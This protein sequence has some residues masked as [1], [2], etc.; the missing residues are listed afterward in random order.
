MTILNSKKETFKTDILM[1]KMTIRNEN[2]LCDIF[3]KKHFMIHA[4]VP[5]LQNNDLFNYKIY[6]T[7]IQCYSCVSSFLFAKIRLFYTN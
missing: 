1:M 6:F 7:Y 4:I 3:K 2:C 5:V